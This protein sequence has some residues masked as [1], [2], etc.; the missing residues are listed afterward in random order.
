M[1]VNFEDVC[2]L[3]DDSFGDVFGV[4]EFD[5]IIWVNYC[6]LDDNLSVKIVDDKVKFFLVNVFGIF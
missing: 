3:C 2:C 6:G 4:I 1:F 5:G